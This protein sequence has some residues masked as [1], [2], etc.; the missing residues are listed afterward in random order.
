MQPY[1]C[2]ASGHLD[3]GVAPAYS[4]AMTKLLDQALSTWLLVSFFSASLVAAQAQTMTIREAGSANTL[5]SVPSIRMLDVVRSSDGTIFILTQDDKKEKSLLVGANQSGPG[6]LVPLANSRSMPESN[7]H[8]AEGQGNTLWIGGTRNTRSATF[9]GLLS[10]GYLAKIDYEGHLIWELEIAHDRENELQSI[11]ALPSGDAVVVGKEG[12]RAWLARVSKD[13][14]LSWEKTFGLGKIAS[15]AVT[16]E[17]ILV[18]AFEA[19][20]DPA[21]GRDMARVALWRFSHAG[22]LLGRQIIRNELADSPSTLWV[23]KVTVAAKAIYVFSAWMHLLGF[24]ETT[25]PLGIVKM[26]MQGHVLWQKEIA[27]TFYQTR[28]GSSLCVH[29]AIVLADGSPLPTVVLKEE[30]SFFDLSRMQVT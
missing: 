1:R 29:A 3:F 7:V 22:E 6:R 28:R 4:A 16:D 17:L 14:Q 18:A 21:S 20:D 9:G 2:N 19:I 8:L 23:M 10:D 26:D 27:G 30:S 12:N 5:W 24:P 25:T 15:V 13:G 11:A